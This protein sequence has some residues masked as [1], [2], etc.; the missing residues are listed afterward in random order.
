MIM[1]FEGMMIPGIIVGV[2]G[3]ALLLCLI[4]MCVGLK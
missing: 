4:P 1:V 2:V 3:I